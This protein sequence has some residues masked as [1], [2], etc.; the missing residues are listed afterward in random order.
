M[1][2][3]IDEDVDERIGHDN[4]NYTHHRHKLL[5]PQYPLIIN[6][7]HD[8]DLIYVR[9]YHSFEHSNKTIPT[10]SYCNH[11]SKM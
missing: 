5:R 11:V 2:A 3:Y 4:S 8:C 6:H 7:L 10:N 1:M 9:S